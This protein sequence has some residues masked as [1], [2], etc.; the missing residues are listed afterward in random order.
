MAGRTGKTHGLTHES[1][2][3]IQYVLRLSPQILYDV[4]PESW[5]LADYV[6]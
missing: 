6:T 5:K 2:G 4:V 1:R 3:E